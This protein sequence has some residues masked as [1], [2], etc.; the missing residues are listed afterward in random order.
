[1]E[2]QD[3]NSGLL[4]LQ[5]FSHA[6][7]FVA[8]ALFPI[9]NPLGMAPIFLTFTAGVDDA[10]RARLARLVAYN[11]FMLATVS[12]LVGSYVL[13]ALSAPVAKP[14]SRR[15]AMGVE[16]FQPG[17]RQLASGH[18]STPPVRQIARACAE[19]RCSLGKN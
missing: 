10:T 13:I 12:L 8:L 16:L 7:L 14:A 18:P 11:S 17:Q 2:G 1:M 5:S 19:G 6:F 15:A 9:V 4:V 3:A